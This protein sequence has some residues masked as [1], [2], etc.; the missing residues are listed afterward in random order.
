[1]QLSSQLQYARLTAPKADPNQNL[2][3][4]V[5]FP[6]YA[7]NPAG[8]I[9]EVMGKTLTPDQLTILASIAN[10]RE[11]NVQASHG[12]GKTQ[13]AAWLTYWGVLA[14]DGIIVTTAPTF[15]QVE[16]LLWRYIAKEEGIIKAAIRSKGREWEAIARNFRLLTV[17]I[18]YGKMQRAWG[19]SP[20]N[21]KP[22][23]FQGL[24]DVRIGI[25]MDEASGIPTLIDEG[26]ST[27]VQGE[28]NWICRQGNPVSNNT[29]FQKACGRSHIRIA[30]W[31]HPNVKWAYRLVV[32]DQHPEGIHRLKPE[33]AEAIGLTS[34]GEVLPQKQWP[35]W[36]QR[37]L[38]PGAVSIAWIET[39][40]YEHGENSVYWE[41][42]VEGRFSTDSGSSIVPSTFFAAARARWDADPDKWLRIAEQHP[43]K[44]GVDVG[45]GGDPHAIAV[46]R[47]PVLLYCAEIPS[48]SAIDTQINLAQRVAR[49]AIALFFNEWVWDERE[50]IDKAIPACDDATWRKQ[51]LYEYDRSKLENKIIAQVDCVGVGSTVAGLI[52]GLDVPSAEVRWGDGATLKDKFMNRKAEDFWSYRQAL[53]SQD[54]AIAPFSR[55]EDQAMSEFS[56]IYYMEQPSTGKLKIEDKDISKARIGH[57]PNLADSI[58]YSQCEAESAVSDWLSVY[59]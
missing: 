45:D 33:V 47:G 48:T 29:A 12:L 1:M 51:I 28:D 24:H 10:N 36:C 11:T 14:W 34:K 19:F 52:A 40:R 31:S 54:T 41:T 16:K 4:R 18:K 56:Q 22:D 37:D 26:A 2:E 49:I 30:V 43:Y 46:S 50:V 5:P 59:G 21:Y 25:L 3:W 9:V 44:I 57:S 15:E 13:V 39:V 6:E 55:Y 58:I 17:E 35:D 38:Y 20:S 42:R 53:Q 23:S 32:T 27:C 7:H 8:F